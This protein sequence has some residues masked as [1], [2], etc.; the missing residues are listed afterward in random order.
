MKSFTKKP[1]APAK[2]IVIK[3]LK[4][5]LKELNLIKAG[6]KEAKNAEDFLNS[7]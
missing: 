4:K 5:A 3:S 2:L 1:T 7:L 6:K